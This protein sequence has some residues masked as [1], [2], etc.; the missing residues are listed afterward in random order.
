[1]SRLVEETEG[2]TGGLP[3]LSSTLL[4]LWQRRSGDRLTIAA[5]ER[6]G[7]VSGAVARLAETAYAQLGPAEAAT[8]RNI[9]VRLAGEGEAKAAVRRQVPLAE[10]DL[11][12]SEAAQR[13][14]AVLTES[15]LLTVG[16]DT[17]EV[18]HE[19]LLRE[20]P[21]LRGWL[22]HDA[23]ARRLHRH[24]TVAT[25][26]WE[27]GGRDPGELYRGARLAAALDLAAERGDLLNEQEREFLDE[28][29]LVSERDA[30]RSR[31]MNRRLRTLLGAAFAALV[32]AGIAGLV[33]LE[34]RKDARDAATVADAQR[35]G[36]QALTDD[37]LD[38]ALLLARTGVELHDSVATRGNLLATLMRVQQGSL[39]VLPD[40]RDVPMI[41]SVAVSPDGGRLA[42]GDS[43]GELQLFDLATRRKLASHRIENALVQRV[44][45]SPDGAMLAAT[46]VANA[47]PTDDTMLD[48][49][50]AGKL[51][52][53]R[54]VVLPRLA[55][56]VEFMGAS[57]VFTADGNVAVL[58]IPFPNN[59]PEVVRVVSARTGEIAPHAF[60]FR[61][62]TTDPV[63]T[64]AAAA[65]WSRAF[66]TTPRTSSTG[67]T[68]GSSTGIRAAA[69][70]RRS[71]PTA[72]RSPSATATARSGCS[73][74]ARR[75]SGRSRPA[76]AAPWRRWRSRPTAGRSPPSART[77]SCS[78]GTRSP[79]GSTIGSPRRPARRSR[80]PRTGGPRS[81]PATTGASRSGTSRA[82][83]CSG[84][85]RCAGRSTWET[86]LRP[87]AWRSARTTGRSP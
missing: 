6:T 62:D 37:R 36:A 38:R 68:C 10:L 60:R 22:E 33:A 54:R 8:A 50:D 14:L 42:F 61:G 41:Y 15:R 86:T 24:I 19:A 21:R 80:S 31:R 73:T 3:L 20:W 27:A 84:R 35:L 75:A 69:A 17:V 67:P 30:E 32:I 79:G 45:F 28:A 81:P 34:Q 78:C 5:Y 49:F 29:R 12:Q 39:G 13:V 43:F 2:Q 47:G 65:C 4:E 25:R 26:D 59:Q 56:P 77:A 53:L 74:S 64:R 48:L 40:V 23:E 52:P 85:S 44:A 55:E 7:G 9:L 70:S 57:P 76:T 66:V 82:A 51:E 71:I 87:A 63:M 72:A 58:Q 46:W 18:S 83:G 11:G 16:G 1:V